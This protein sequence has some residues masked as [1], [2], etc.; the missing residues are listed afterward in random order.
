MTKI[1][2]IF[3][4]GV[5]LGPDEPLTNPLAAVEMPNLQALMDGRKL[6]HGNAPFSS[7]TATLLSLDACLGVKGVPQSATGQT[8][9]LTGVNVPAAL[10]YHYGPKPNPAVAEYVTNGNLFS[11]LKK[12]GKHATLLNAYPPRYFEGIHSGRRLYSAIP[13]AVT[14]AGIPLRTAEDLFAGRALSADFTGLG[15]REM[16]K[17]PDAP[18]LTPFDSGAR[19]ASLASEVDFAMFEY[20]PS[21]YAGHGQNMAQ[22][23]QLLETFD[24]VLGGLIESWDK[25]EGLVLITSDHGNLEDLGTRR[26]TLNPVPALVIGEPALRLS[27]FHGLDDLTGIAPAILR[28]I[29]AN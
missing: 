5:G 1:L 14:H 19:M 9:L 23:K 18:V 13:L 28:T 6:I 12:D 16:L 25:S 22:A 11:R 2:F 17:I 24:Q 15:W 26:H 10:G 4:D 29:N 7:S 20:W 3:L 27:F 8:V 21:D